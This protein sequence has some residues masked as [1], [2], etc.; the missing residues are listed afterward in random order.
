[1]TIQHASRLE[2]RRLRE[3]DRVQLLAFLNKEPG[4]NLFLINNLEQYGLRNASFRFWAVF[5]AGDIRAVLMM[6][7][8]RG[9]FFAPNKAD[10]QPLVEIAEREQLRFTM[11]QRELLDAVLAASTLRVV[12]REE[13]NFCELR[14]GDLRPAVLKVPPGLVVRRAEPADVDRLASFYFGTAGFEHLSYMEV[15]HSMMG[16]VRHLRTYLADKDHHLVS[17]ASTSAE[18]DVAA[19]IGGVWTAPDARNHGY[20]TVVVARLADELLKTGRTVYLF[21]LEDN[22]PAARVY[23]KIGFRVIGK[24]SV[25]YLAEG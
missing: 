8:Q 23:E 4:Y 13:H 1:M 7:E 20:S 18:S 24:W 5:A 17:A 3:H 15:R 21:Y 11:G 12:R 14:P 19:M 22:A 6:V 16:R 10:V 9:A 25:I 2:V